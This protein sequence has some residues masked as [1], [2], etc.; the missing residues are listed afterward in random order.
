MTATV[1]V[2]ARA[3][4]HWDAAG[5]CWA[6]EHGTFRLEAGGGGAGAVSTPIRIEGGEPG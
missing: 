6:V 5:E 1:A 3:F 4:A 2:D